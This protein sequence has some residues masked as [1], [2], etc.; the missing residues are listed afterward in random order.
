MTKKRK[1]TIIL[2]VSLPSEAFKKSYRKTEKKPLKN[3]IS[4]KIRTFLYEKAV[5]RHLKNGDRFKI[6]CYSSLTSTQDKAKEFASL[7]APEGT[8]VIA[9]SQSRGR[10]R[11]GRSFFS[12]NGSGIYMSVIFRPAVSAPLLSPKELTLITALSAVATAEAIEAHTEKK[13]EIK[14][15][16]DVFCDGLKVSGI[17]TEAELNAETGTY[18]SVTV[19]IGVNLFENAFPSEL[20][21]IAGALFEK[22]PRRLSKLKCLITAEML[23]RLDRYYSRLARGDLSFTEEYKKRSFV[24]GKS[25]DIIVGDK[26]VGHGTA[27]SL[28]PD[29]S[30]NIKKENGESVT[31]SFGEVRIRLGE[32]Q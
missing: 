13:A 14:W 10:G 9:E 25:V 15:V 21:G 28:N 19:G 12:P 26:T 32:G 3:R 30:L 7:G 29:C 18:G 11:Q 17:L 23:C 4:Q 22:K 16:N 5:K 8:A 6:H 1:Y 2:T 31:V 27:V 24:L 20:R